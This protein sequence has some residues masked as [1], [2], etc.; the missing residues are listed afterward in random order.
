MGREK[1]MECD[2]TYHARHCIEFANNKTIVLF[3]IPRDMT[4]EMLFPHFGENVFCSIP[5]DGDKNKG[6]AFVEVASDKEVTEWVKKDVIT[7]GEDMVK[8]MRVVD[9]PKIG[10]LMAD[11]DKLNL[12]PRLR[13]PLP[14][15]Q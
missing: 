13:A 8:L 6:Y 14:N 12:G 2:R 10:K 15:S 9:T 5:K 7:V 3:G 4:R 1:F 11:L